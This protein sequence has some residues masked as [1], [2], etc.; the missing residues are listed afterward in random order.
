MAAK[1]R[2]IAFRVEDIPAMAEFFKSGFGM[3]IEQ[4]RANGAV[5]LSDGTINITLLPTTIAGGSHPLGIDHLGFTFDNDEE[6]KKQIE[7]AGGK[8]RN[9]IGM[10]DVHFEVK[11]EGP[12]NIVVD[13]GHWVGTAPVGGE[14]IA[15]QA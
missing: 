5:D 4:E 11:Y 2:H 15:I 14:V 3:T 12:E 10:S 8:E 7:A 1:I 13:L 9:T 6:G